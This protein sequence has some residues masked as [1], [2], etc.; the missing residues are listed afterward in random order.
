MQT[1]YEIL[2]KSKETGA[3]HDSSRYGVE[4]GI[5]TNVQDPEKLGR[6]KF[7]L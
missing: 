6:I 5:V 2:Q 7:Q 3:G 4:V 1:F